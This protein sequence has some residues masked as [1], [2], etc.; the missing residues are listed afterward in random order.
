[1]TDTG[2]AGSKSS[3]P[4]VASGGK[5]LLG[6]TGAAKVL[7]ASSPGDS[8]S[9]SVNTLSS[10][11]VGPQVALVTAIDAKTSPSFGVSLAPS[12]GGDLLSSLTVLYFFSIRG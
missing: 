5:D 6:D 10:P 12:S 11:E 1:M 8:T 7:T 3:V 4:I 2:G 9:L